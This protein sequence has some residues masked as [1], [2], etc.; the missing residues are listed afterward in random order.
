MPEAR[1]IFLSHAWP[2][3]APELENLIE[4]ILIVEDGGTILPAQLPD[5]IHRTVSGHEAPA[6]GAAKTRGGFHDLTAAYQRQMI[7]AALARTN[8]SPQGAAA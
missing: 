7:K 5:R 8:G 4:R 6:T 2:G 3:N 1:A